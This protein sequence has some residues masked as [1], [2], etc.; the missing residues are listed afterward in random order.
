MLDLSEP[1]Y[2]S[3]DWT[4]IA[5][6]LLFIV[7]GTGLLYRTL[8]R[9]FVVDGKASPVSWGIRTSLGRRRSFI[10]KAVANDRSGK[11]EDPAG[12]RLQASCASTPVPGK[13]RDLGPNFTNS[14]S[15]PRP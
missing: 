15:N 7:A 11:D 6:L 1:S 2:S 9:V 14:D 5:G 8:A 12:P 4:V 10:Q 3:V 13:S